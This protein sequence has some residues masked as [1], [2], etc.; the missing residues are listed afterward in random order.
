MKNK[1]FWICVI[2]WII[3][4][5]IRLIHHQPWLDESN[6]WEIAHYMQWGSVLSSLKYEGH[7]LG[8]FLIL[9]PFAKLNLGYP[10]SML[11]I[12]WFFCFGAIFTLWKYA[13]FNNW[14]KTFITFSFPFLAVYP[15]VARCYSVGIF[16]LFILIALFKDRTKRPILYSVLIFLCANTSLMA[17]LGVFALGF[18]LIFDLFKQKQV[19]DLIICLSIFLLCAICLIIQVIGVDT[20]HLPIG[21]IPVLSLD[22]LTNTFI[23]G[24]I[25]NSIL[26]IFF[27]FSFGF[28]LFRDKQS[29]WIISVTYILLFSFF[30]FIYVGNFWHYYFFYIY[31]ICACWIYMQNR[32]ISEKYKNYLSILLCIISLLFVIEYRID[33]SVYGSQSRVLAEHIKNHS[34]SKSI[35]LSKVFLATVPYLRKYGEPY[36]IGMYYSENENY[37]VT[38]DFDEIKNVM[39]KNKENYLYINNCSPIPNLTK[40]GQLMQFILDKNIKNIYCIY[41][42]KIDN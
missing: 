14:L 42:V 22:W 24:K 39:S 8:W 15:I 26:L 29:F 11:F 32:N 33:I 2:F 36:D 17:A 10:Y 20:S 25:I 35:F 40:D 7:F 34:N 12:N 4:T 5:L 3:I 6:A 18:I 16:L 9:M 19:K 31:L 37:D 13:P 23:F 38:L 30:Q 21:E 41:R 27:I 1:A 28:L